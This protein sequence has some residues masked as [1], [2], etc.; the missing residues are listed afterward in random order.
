[1]CVPFH[2]L[3]GME[4]VTNLLDVLQCSNGF[5]IQFDKEGSIVGLKDPVSKVIN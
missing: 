1:M 5:T 4:K 2:V 3:T